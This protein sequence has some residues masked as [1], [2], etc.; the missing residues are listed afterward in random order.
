MAGVEA[1]VGRRLKGDGMR[2]SEPGA[3]AVGR[4]RAWFKSEKG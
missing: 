4:R 2:G 3:D 1:V